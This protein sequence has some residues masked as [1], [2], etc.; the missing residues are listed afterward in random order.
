MLH[1]LTPIW[2]AKHDTARR[3]IQ[4]MSQV[5]DWSKGAGFYPNE[6][7]VNG[8][9][10]A[11]PNVKYKAKHMPAMPWQEVPEFFEE[12]GKREG[13]SARALGLLILT[14]LRSGEVRG[15]EWSE[16]DGDT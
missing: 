13:V 7:P 5:F 14:G 2:T 16:I 11:L 8:V 9:K 4:R 12:L 15:A 1:V 10:R 6:N 3:I